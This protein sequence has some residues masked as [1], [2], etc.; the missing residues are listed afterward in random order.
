MK[1]S[2]EDIRESTRKTIKTLLFEKK[3]APSGNTQPALMVPN[4]QWM[5]GVFADY[6]RAAF[7][8]FLKTPKFSTKCDGDEWG[9]YYP[10]SG[11][12]GITNR[13]T[14]KN[15]GTLCLNGGLKRT[16]EQWIGV[17]LHEMCHMYVYQNGFSKYK[18]AHGEEF[19]NIAKKVNAKVKKYGVQVL[20]V[21]DGDVI[22]ADGNEEYAEYQSMFG[23]GKTKNQQPQTQQG[24]GGQIAICLLTSKDQENKYWICPLKQNE[25]KTAQSVV[26]KAKGITSCKFY[27]V[28]S[29]KLAKA[30]T[31]PSV[32]SGFGGQTYQDAVE[33]FCS[34]YGEWD[35]KKLNVNNMKPVQ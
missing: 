22:E 34:Y 21:D 2:I 23:K 8:G 35:Y 9:C 3:A 30:K 7:G 1:Y 6:N 15:P 27:I 18:D 25:I 12:F 26:K 32:L 28:F 14:M 10:G 16:K 11:M 31:D 20:V 33:N 13:Y 17:M 4:P 5:A 29:D 19:M 24:Q